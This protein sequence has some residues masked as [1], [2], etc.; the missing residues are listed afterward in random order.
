[1]LLLW[2]KR[3]FDEV[4]RLLVLQGQ[5]HAKMVPFERRKGKDRRKLLFV[6][7]LNNSLNHA[8]LITSLTLSSASG[9]ESW[10]RLR[11]H[12][13]PL[14][15]KER[16]LTSLHLSP[17]HDDFWRNCLEEK[18]MLAF[19]AFYPRNI[20]LNKRGLRLRILPFGITAF[21]SALYC[22]S[23]FVFAMFAHWSIASR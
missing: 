11:S 23:F 10:N 3:S 19:A 18:I 15:L 9:L 12:V 17:F 8:A 14:F 4:R 21:A 7:T 6:L 1:M 16:L 5:L 13:S 2:K 22:P 20:L